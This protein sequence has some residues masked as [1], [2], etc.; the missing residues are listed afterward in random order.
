[1]AA[2]KIP[3]DELGFPT[4]TPGAAKHGDPFALSS[5]RRAREALEF[6]LGVRDQGFNIFVI[7]DD[8]SG[9]MTATRTFLERVIKDRP[10]QDDWVYLNNFRNPHQPR[11]YRLP[12]G[13]G[14]DFKNRMERLVPQLRDA[15]TKAF[16]G[17]EYQSMIRTRTEEVGREIGKT[18]EAL[19]AE[20]Q[21]H[22]LDIAETPQGPV[23][24]QKREEGQEPPEPTPEQREKLNA[25]G[26]KIARDLIELNRRAVR[27]QAEVGKWVREVSRQ[28]GDRAIGA[29][30]DDLEG[31]F[32]KYP[33][34]SRWLVQLRVDVLDNIDLFREGGR[35]QQTGAVER[36][37]QRYGVNLV[38]DHGDEDHPQVVVESNPTYENV[39]GSIE[40]RQVQGSLETDFTLIRPG[41]LHR[42][43]GGVLVMR[44]DA[45]AF[46]P[47]TWVFLKN[48]LRDNEIRI[49][50]RIASPLPI[51]G[52]PKPE[53]IPL[54]IKVVLI[55]SPKWYYL[56]YLPDP[57]LATYF[58]VKADIDGEM[59]LT[60]ANV[61]CYSGLIRGMAENHGGSCADGAIST[62]LGLASRWAGQRD[63]L[64][65]RFEMVE[66]VIGEA[67][68]IAKQ[69]GERTEI[70]TKD[71]LAAITSRRRR[72]S[73]IEDQVHERIS[74]RTVMIDTKGSVTGQINGLTVM[75]VGDHTFGAPTRITARVSI[76]RRG[77]TNIERESLL[78]GPIQQKGVMVLQGFLAGHFAK[79][80][81]LSFD[82]SITFEQ[83]YS[84]VEGD[85]ASMAELLAILSDIAGIPIRQDLAI[86]GSVNQRG[87]S[88]TIG[89]VRHKIEG[90]YRTCLDDGGL[91][92]TQGVVVPKAN[93]PHLILRREVID[94]IRAGKFHIYSVE[95]V[96][97]AIDLFFGMPAGEADA[98]G[99]YAVETV[100]GKVQKAL[101]EFDRV[102]TERGMRAH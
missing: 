6:G 19:R 18:F 45:L 49:E 92:G 81:P 68:Q 59:E 74:D 14:R 60:D 27:Q 13:M 39:F 73:Q 37:D 72:N 84:G 102:L 79:R 82:C 50:P 53:P 31:E 2:R 99:V 85:S 54:N 78:S 43:N 90:F 20:A 3:A 76:G 75:Q 86:T 9:R 26:E 7:G 21:S 32:G 91:S 16:T 29:L 67:V 10:A 23:L 94:A 61:N 56:A 30:M 87:L 44:A 66:D 98:N 47:V 46:N 93:E 52:S 8:R 48:A 62:L 11:P 69:D 58:K 89:G 5:H 35:Q 24:V 12:N 1:M 95:T 38:V 17:D 15:F 36:P 100:Y 33:G 41:A 80:I 51:A 70:N 4:I 55:G 101:E 42:A 65:A 22:G 34:L 25:I 63:K 64:S 57:D 88:Q 83:T 77:I 28:M 96:E 40:F 71:I 97:D